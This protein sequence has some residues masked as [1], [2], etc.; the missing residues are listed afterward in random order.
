MQTQKEEPT[1]MHDRYAVT[2]KDGVGIVGH[3]PRKFS[4]LCHSFLTRGGT[5]DTVVMGWRHFAED[6]CTPRRSGCA[7]HVHF[8]REQA[9]TLKAIEST[10]KDLNTI[11]VMATIV[12]Q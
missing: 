9:A 2:I 8:F 7:I 5:I 12:P 1:N 4:K 3:V 11:N 6:L 10:G